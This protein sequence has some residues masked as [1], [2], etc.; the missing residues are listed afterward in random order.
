MTARL[1]GLVALV[2]YT[3]SIPLAN[4]MIG[5]VG[6]QYF[7]DGPH[8]IPVGFGFDAP[9]GVLCIGVALFLRDIIQRQ[10]G[11]GWASAAIVVGAALS[12]LVA[13]P[14][15]AI[16]SAVAFLLGELVDLSIYTPLADRNRPLA[17]LLS[18]T[19]GAVVDSLL[20]LWIA[21]GSVAFW[22]GQVIGKTYMAALGAVLI[23][24]GSHALSDRLAASEA[25][26]VR[27][28]A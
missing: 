8:V 4:W 7:P 2:G 11:I 18:G 20:F 10:L 26:T 15:L 23:W 22:Q 9:S 16:A 24:I 17:V 14:A 13:S 28:V 6:T 12:F 25:R 27:G 21:F 19:V 3:A 1:L 5:N